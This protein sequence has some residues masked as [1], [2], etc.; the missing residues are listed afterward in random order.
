[1]AESS[2]GKVAVV[3]ARNRYQKKDRKGKFEN[4]WFS[5]KL[6]PTGSFNAIDNAIL[7]CLYVLIY[8]MTTTLPPL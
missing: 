4:R 8:L 7:I 2:A 1:M 5:I 6:A 3:D